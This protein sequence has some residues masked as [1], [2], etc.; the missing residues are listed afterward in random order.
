MTPEER[1]AQLEARVKSMFGCWTRY[2][3]DVFEYEQSHGT[4]TTDQK[5]VMAQA[6]EREGS[7]G[8]AGHMHEENRRKRLGRPENS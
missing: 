4:P 1:L 3:N 7:R 2:L 5:I 8:V 6:V